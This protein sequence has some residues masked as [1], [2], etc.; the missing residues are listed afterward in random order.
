M[1]EKA[2]KYHGKFIVAMQILCPFT[3]APFLVAIH[4]RN[5]LDPHVYILLYNKYCL[6]EAVPGKCTTI[7]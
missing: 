5:G 6:S 4:E 7:A 2:I 1:P 3:F